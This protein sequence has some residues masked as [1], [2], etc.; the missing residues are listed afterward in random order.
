MDT[1]TYFKDY[2]RKDDDKISFPKGFPDLKVNGNYHIIHRYDN[3]INKDRILNDK[4]NQLN[5]WLKQTF[6]VELP[7]QSEN[8]VYFA[9]KIFNSENKNDFIK[10]IDWLLDPKDN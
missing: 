2:I 3:S 8:N 5:M 6:P 1:N 9:S 7:P 10:I 4:L